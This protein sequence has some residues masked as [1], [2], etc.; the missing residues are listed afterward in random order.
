MEPFLASLKIDYI[1]MAAVIYC[2]KKETIM[3]RNPNKAAVTKFSGLSVPCHCCTLISV[4]SRVLLLVRKGTVVH[5]SAV[6]N[7]FSGGG[8][9]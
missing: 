1:S 8:G 9:G 4:F 6:Y 3:D 5:F 2:R 7:Y